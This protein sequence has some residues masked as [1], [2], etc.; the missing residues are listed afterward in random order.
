MFQ[1]ITFERL[2]HTPE[3]A[4]MA[5]SVCDLGAAHGCAARMSE[6]VIP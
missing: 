2:Q 1:G 5:A 4:V 6:K 3:A